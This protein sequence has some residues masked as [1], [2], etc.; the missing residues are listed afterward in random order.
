M[1]IA[2]RALLLLIVLFARISL[3]IAQDKLDTS[4]PLYAKNS[5][6]SISA[7]TLFSPIDSSIKGQCDLT[8]VYNR[9]F[10][11]IDTVRTV[12]NSKNHLSILP[13]V[14]Y[15]LQTGF[16]GVISANVGFYTNNGDH[17]NQKISSLLSSI[18]YSQ[19][20]QII[21]PIQ[22]D[23]WAKKDKYNVILDW[24]YMRYPSTTFGLG[25]RSTNDDGYTIDFSYIKLHQ[26][27]L[28]KIS[29]NLYA[30]LGYY[31]DYFWDVEEIDPPTGVVTSFQKYG[32]KSTVT[33]S[34]VAFRLLFDSRKNQINPDAG[35]FLN[36]VDRPNFT[37]L[38]SDNN[39]QSLLIEAR[40]YFNFPK[41]TKNVLAFW[42]YNWLTLSGKPPYLLL[43]S[44]GWDDFYNTGR[45]YIQGRY[46]GR[47]MIYLETEYRFGVSNNGMFGG[48]VFANAQSFSKDLSKQLQIIAPGAGVGIRIKLNKFSGANL[49]IDYGWGF[50]GSQ[51]VSV[52][53][54]EV[55]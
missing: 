47:D 36:I 21:F 18:T 14:G 49:C 46:R 1:K 51:G 38:G 23:I 35:W 10:K 2:L 27:V 41:N 54:G 9:Y 22:F 6:P 53:L 30:G 55:F 8:D 34:G 33:S 24:R 43:P 16:A 42:S 29:R 31:Y 19:Y 4:G 15:S 3:S 26:T 39:W 48:V 45:G 50:T 5:V 11:H 40:R 25:G 20:N 32:L 52:N 44:T 17:K 28:R 37:F 12:D 7:D 13:V